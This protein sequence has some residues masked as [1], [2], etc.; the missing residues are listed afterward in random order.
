MQEQVYY[1]LGQLI[2]IVVLFI[3]SSGL[4]LRGFFI[5]VNTDFKL[6]CYVFSSK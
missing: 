2:S 1:A 4:F 5:R 6:G 3:I